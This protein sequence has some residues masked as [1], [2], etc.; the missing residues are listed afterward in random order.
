MK[1]LEDMPCVPGMWCAW[2]G[3]AGGQQAWCSPSEAGHLHG[4]LGW[5][6][7]QPRWPWGETP[8][9]GWLSVSRWVA[10]LVLEWWWAKRTHFGAITWLCHSVMLYKSLPPSS[11]PSRAYSVTRIKMRPGNSTA[12]LWYTVQVPRW[13]PSLLLVFHFLSQHP[14]P[15]LPVF[16]VQPWCQ[17][18][19]CFSPDSTSEWSLPSP[20]L[21]LLNWK[22]E[23]FHY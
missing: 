5:C 2:Q 11:K 7:D 21:S 22:W 17:R 20:R 18:Q 15:F 19:H 1:R 12:E 10:K 13:Q 16:A 23:T 6:Q 8:R 4:V 9:Q 3:L 14:H